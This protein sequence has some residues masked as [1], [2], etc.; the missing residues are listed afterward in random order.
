[1]NEE[2]G[3]IHPFNLCGE[4]DTLVCFDPFGHQWLAWPLRFRGREV[5]LLEANQMLHA[6]H[7]DPVPGEGRAGE[8]L[9]AERRATQFLELA[10]RLDHG[11]RTL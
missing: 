11:E 1:M 2:S 5:F 4:A 3:S 10:R 8:D 9:F 7:K 6:A